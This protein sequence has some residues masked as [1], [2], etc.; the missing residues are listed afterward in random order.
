MEHHGV[1]CSTY[2]VSD[3]RQA[4]SSRIVNGKPHDARKL[5]KINR[6]HQQFVWITE[7]LLVYEMRNGMGAH[8]VCGWRKCKSTKEP[9][10]SA[11]EWEGHTDEHCEGC[12]YVNW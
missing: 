2:P 9:E 3:P 7:P 4:E 8:E 5:Q 12:M 11:E 10:Q 1:S 6:K